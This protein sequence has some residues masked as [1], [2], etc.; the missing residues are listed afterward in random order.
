V[1]GHRIEFFGRCE[2]CN[3]PPQGGHAWQERA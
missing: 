2:Q 3:E 1:L